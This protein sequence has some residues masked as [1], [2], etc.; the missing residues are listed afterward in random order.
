MK[1]IIC[2]FFLCLNVYSG[3]A[4]N[5]LEKVIVEKYYI[6]TENDTLSNGY[7]GILPIGSVTYRI[8]LDLLPGYTFQAAYGSPDHELKLTTS[9]FF[10]N[11]IENG[12]V[13][14]NVI[15]R[16]TLKKNTVMLDSWLSAGAAG[17]Q[18]YGVMNDFDDTI[19][20]IKHDKFILENKN[21]KLNFGLTQKDGLLDAEMV[22]RPTFFGIDSLVNI[23]KYQH[24]GSVFKTKNGAWAC[25]GKGALGADSLTENRVLIAQIT[26]DGVFE[27][28]L[29]IQI[30]T[31]T[32][33]VSQNYV[34]RNPIGNE[35]MLPSLIFKS[36]EINKRKKRVKRQN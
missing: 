20:T 8:Y 21:D 32:K 7:S 29:N 9:T 13:I 25:M 35:I 22:P 10:F 17:E 23:F 5:G 6:S 27:F 34:A 16:R 36:E 1:N 19:E 3:I 28:E 14:P 18:Y 31:P 12:D 2:L 4:Q 11:N 30:G 15:P 33:G 24:L 26:T